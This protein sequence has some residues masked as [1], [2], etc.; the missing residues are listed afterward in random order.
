[1]SGVAAGCIS[2]S[3]LAVD[4]IC[5]FNIECNLHSIYLIKLWTKENDMVKVNDKTNLKHKVLEIVMDWFSE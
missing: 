1:M 4:L 5:R 3:I 2:S